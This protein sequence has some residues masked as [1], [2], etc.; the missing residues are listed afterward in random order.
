[1]LVATIL[2]AVVC[3]CRLAITQFIAYNIA[4]ILVFVIN[5]QLYGRPP[6][7]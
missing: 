5:T 1:M 6:L 3:C 2:S 4:A 7:G